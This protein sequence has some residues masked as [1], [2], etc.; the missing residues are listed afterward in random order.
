AP[1]AKPA[2]PVTGVHA[3]LQLDAP[4]VAPDPH[5]VSDADAPLNTFGDINFMRAVGIYPN[6][7]RY[8]RRKAR[9]AE[10]GPLGWAGRLPV[11]PSEPPGTDFVPVDDRWR[12]ALPAWD[13]WPRGLPD[14]SYHQNVLKGDYPIFGTQNLFLNVTALSDTFAEARRLPVAFNTQDQ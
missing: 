14:D 1:E 4:V 2:A 3:P 7:P 11:I 5:A 13:R 6:G 10:G 12:I 8:G 9:E